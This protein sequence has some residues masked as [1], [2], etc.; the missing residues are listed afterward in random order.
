MRHRRGAAAAGRG[1]LER[2]GNLRLHEQRHVARELAQRADQEA[3]HGRDFRDAIALRVPREV[4]QCELQLLG[5]RRR[6]VHAALAQRR[7][8]ADRAAELQCR[9]PAAN[10]REP[11]PVALDRRQ[12]S[13]G[14]EAQRH[15]RPLLQP[16]AARKRRLCVHSRERGERAGQAREIR[17]DRGQCGTKLQ[18]QPRVHHVLAGRAPVH[19][20][21]GLCV[22]SGDEKRELSHQG[23]RRVAG[24]RGRGGERVDVEE[25]GPALGADRDG[26]GGGH[27]AGAGLGARERRL[28]VEHRL[29]PAVIGEN[30]AH[31]L[32]REQRVE[33]ALRTPGIQDRFLLRRLACALILLRS[34]AVRSA[35]DLALVAPVARAT[36]L[37]F[38]NQKTRSRPAPAG[39][40][41]IPA[42]PCHAA[43]AGQ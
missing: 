6:D 24:L 21:R 23:D 16:G 5:E 27:E 10:L 3:Q 7:E 17:V 31:R 40:R 39:S 14:L 29:Q 19:A 9:D 18:D 43:S 32:R 28:E 36:L 2:F 33:Q 42:R 30:A 35:V 26:R 12:E 1:R 34:T 15:R 25:L 41:S 13:R 11:D 8:R 37:S 20:A 4:G 22:A 38:S